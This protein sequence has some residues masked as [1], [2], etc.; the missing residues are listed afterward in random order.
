M[1]PVVLEDGEPRFKKN[2]IVEFLL[3]AGPFDMN[4]LAMMPWEDEDR[5]Q[6]AQLI[7]Y[8]ISGFGELPYVGAK[9]YSKAVAEAE[10][11]NGG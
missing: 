1:Q 6:L 11:L 4:Q 2:A 5:E 8:G 3:R 7:G 9:T 10:K